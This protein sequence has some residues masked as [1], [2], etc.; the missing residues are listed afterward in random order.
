[1]REDPLRQELDMILRHYRRGLMN[2]VEFTG[3]IVEQVAR[4]RRRIPVAARHPDPLIRA[5]LVDALILLGSGPAGE[6][7]ELVRDDEAPEVRAAVARHHA[8]LAR[9]L[10]PEDL[11][12]NGYIYRADLATRRLSRA[13]IDHLLAAHRDLDLIA[14]NPHLPPDV[15]ARLF[16]HPSPEVRRALATRA[17]LSAEQLADLAADPD[18]AV[19]T[20]VSVHP[21]L[22][23]EQRAA[24]DIDVAH[25]PWDGHYPHVWDEIHPYTPPPP[26]LPDLAD[27]IRQATSVNP[28]LRRLAAHDPRLPVDLVA[29]LAA[30]P[31]PEVRALLAHYHP[32]APPELL[33][34]VYREDTHSRRN[35]L[36]TLP[37][38]PA[39]GGGQG[40]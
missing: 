32:Q 38:F 18:V 1:M 37:N 13:T 23:E 20:T 26:P 39:A 8:E 28:L 5:G 19:R 3:E 24:I 30:D 12:R 16:G 2:D 11:P 15:V 6:V 33:L 17:D 35:R 10:E 25:A 29:A 22:T 7:L 34:R 27:S 36:P 4:H 14:P 9:E 40:A 31:D 21:A